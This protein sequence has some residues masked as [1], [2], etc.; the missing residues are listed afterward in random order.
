MPSP[1]IY[2]FYPI[3]T[4]KC[5]RLHRHGY[6]RNAHSATAEVQFG[7]ALLGD[8]NNDGVANVADRRNGDTRLIKLQTITVHKQAVSFCTR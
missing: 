3:V 6:N 5:L 4:R 8:V 2:T 7:I 1:S